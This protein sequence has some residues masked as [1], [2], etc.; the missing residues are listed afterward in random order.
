MYDLPNKLSDTFRSRSSNHL[1]N[2]EFIKDCTTFS[3]A[4]KVC[5]Y[6]SIYIYKWPGRVL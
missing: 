1:R 2:K 5:V 6:T 4:L 3:A